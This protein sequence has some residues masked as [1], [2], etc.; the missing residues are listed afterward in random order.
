M[1]EVTSRETPTTRGKQDATR[2]NNSARDFRHG[3]DCYQ[4]VQT[5]NRI[6]RSRSQHG[7][8]VVCHT[9]ADSTVGCLWLSSQIGL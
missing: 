3:H 2:T 1:F 5:P 9:P 4:I 8:A 6:R 7:F